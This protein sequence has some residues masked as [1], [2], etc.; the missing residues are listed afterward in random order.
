MGMNLSHRSGDADTGA[1]NSTIS[2]MMPSQFFL[3]A[4]SSKQKNIT[5][6]PR[7]KPINETGR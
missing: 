4:N 6:A 5:L 7:L 2:S 1:P 3:V